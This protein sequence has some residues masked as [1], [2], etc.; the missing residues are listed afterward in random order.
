MK[1]EDMSE[2]DCCGE[3]AETT[4]CWVT[5]IETFACDKCRGVAEETVTAQDSPT[6]SPLVTQNTSTE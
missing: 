4:R 5:G 2:C 6:R 3:Y 1:M